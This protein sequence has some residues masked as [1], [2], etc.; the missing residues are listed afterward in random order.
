MWRV[1]LLAVLTVTSTV[2]QQDPSELDTCAGACACV[3][4]SQSNGWRDQG[5][6]QDQFSA[7]VKV[8]QWRPGLRVTATWN[9]FVN[10]DNVYGASQAA[11]T[12]SGA[13]SLTVELTRTLQV[14][15]DSAFVL[16]GHGTTSMPTSFSCT[17]APN[18]TRVSPTTATVDCDL[19]ARWAITNPYPL[20][21]DARV[22]AAERAR[23]L[24]RRLACA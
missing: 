1:V 8:A 20:L 11:G 7:R 19:G 3:D 5:T 23:S 21:T 12:D 4:E 13:H 24:A 2:G 14:G 17:N 18:T 22:R 10:I 6:G 15:S 9:A 16:M